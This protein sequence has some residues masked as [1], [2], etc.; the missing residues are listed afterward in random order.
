[1]RF[2]AI[3]P[4]F[5]S[6]EDG[7]GDALFGRESRGFGERRGDAEYWLEDARR[8]CGVRLGRGLLWTTTFSMRMSCGAGL[9]LDFWLKIPIVSF[10]TSD[11]GAGR[12]RGTDSSGDYV[13]PRT[14]GWIKCVR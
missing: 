10:F 11:G 12:A 2:R 5:S 6:E 3:A 7:Y 13:K 1:M 8:P 14:K 9:S 4:R